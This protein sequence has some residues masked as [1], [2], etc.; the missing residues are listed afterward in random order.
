LRIDEPNHT[1]I[2]NIVRLRPRT[3]LHHKMPCFFK[4]PHCL[5][6]LGYVSK[7][8]VIGHVLTGE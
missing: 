4:F 1:L 8:H 5:P 6:Y 3:R 7:R 2:R